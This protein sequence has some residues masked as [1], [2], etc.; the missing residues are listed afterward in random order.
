[1]IVG[2]NN[3]GK[4]KALEEIEYGLRRPSAEHWMSAP[5]SIAGL[6]GHREADGAAVVDWLAQRYHT[7][8]ASEGNHLL[9]PVNGMPIDLSR[10]GA[11]WDHLAEST[12]GAQLADYLVLRMPP[13]DRLN[14]LSASVRPS[15]QAS[16][17][18]GPVQ[19]VSMNETARENLTA[20]L[21]EAFGIE[22]IVDAFGD[23]IHLRVSPEFRQEH[24]HTTT[25]T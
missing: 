3:S 20:A 15:V 13:A 19:E 11:I 10:P 18:D 7:A 16:H 8:T 24:F 4:S 2:P 14:Y 5:V 9:L 12:I 23:Q 1:M 6:K 21:R 25:S 17:G 22:L